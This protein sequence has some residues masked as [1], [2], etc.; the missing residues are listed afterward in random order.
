MM[1]INVY[2]LKVLGNIT[3]LYLNTIPEK[4]SVIN[5]K[6]H[7]IETKYQVL[8]S[9]FNVIDGEEIESVDLIVR[10]LK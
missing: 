7:N 1:T 5:I 8:N 4:G 9:I 10:E 6:N 2:E 3:T